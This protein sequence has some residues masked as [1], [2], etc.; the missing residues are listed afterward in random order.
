MYQAWSVIAGE[1]PTTSKWNILGTNDAAF[2]DGSG[3]VN[4]PANPYQAAAKRTTAQTNIANQT[5]TKVQLSSEDYDTNNNFDSSTNY[6]YTVPVSGK[7]KVNWNLP[8]VDPEGRLTNVVAFIYKNGS[9]LLRCGLTCPAIIN[10]AAYLCL[11][12]SRDIPLTAGDYIELWGYG[13]TDN[14]TVFD[15]CDSNNH[16]WLSARLESQA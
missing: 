15:F 14:S 11:N 8:F 9:E 7:Y 5:T 13:S 16:A 12:G 1:Q 10:I 6:R 2:N 3:I 4:A